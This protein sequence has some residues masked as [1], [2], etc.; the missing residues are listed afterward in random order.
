MTITMLAGQNR[1]PRRKLVCVLP[2]VRQWFWISTNCGDTVRRIK[3][4]QAFIV[5]FR[6]ELDYAHFCFPLAYFF[7]S[8]FLF[9][10]SWWMI[11]FY[12]QIY[13]PI[14]IR[15]AIYFSFRKFYEIW[16]LKVYMNRKNNE[17][18]KKL[19]DLKIIL[20]SYQSNCILYYVY[21]SIMSNAAKSFDVLITGLNVI[22]LC[23]I[24]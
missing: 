22:I 20:L 7:L 6:L 9:I 12:I 19:A 15:I 17:V 23:V 14:F 11:T 10:Q 5:H 18:S 13:V 21:S 8:L 2:T 24:F 4:R 16:R 1:F 3:Q